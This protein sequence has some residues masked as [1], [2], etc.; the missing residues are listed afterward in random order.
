MLRNRTEAPYQSL[1]LFSIL[2]GLSN[3]A[4]IAVINSAAETVSDQSI[5]WRYTLLY[6]LVVGIF[7]YSKTLTLNW[8]SELVEK[9]IYQIRARLADKARRSE[10]NA[11]QNVGRPNIYARI[12]QDATMISNTSTT[13]INSA[14]S[15]VMIF[16]A[17]VYIAF[18]S[19]WSFALLAAGLAFGYLYFQLHTDKFQRLWKKVSEQ[20]TEFFSKLD[21]ILSG[22]KEIKINSL[23]NEK[24]FE[25]YLE[26]NAQLKHLR[27]KTSK[28]YNIA[29]IFDQMLFYFMLGVI[30]FVLPKFHTEHA[31]V[32]IKVVA[33]ILFIA[34]PLEGIIFSIPNFAN[35]NQSA[36]NILE[37]EAAL[38]ADL[39]EN[40][41]INEDHPLNS[42]LHTILPFESNIV[43]QNLTHQYDNKQEKGKSG[44]Q[45]GPIDMTLHKGEILFITGGNGSGKSTFVHL[46]TGLL[47]P[48]TGEILVDQSADSPGI[49]ITPQNISAYRNLFGAIFSNYHLFDKLYGI[50]TNKISIA[51]V[52]QALIEMGL[53]PEKVHYHGGQFS[54]LNLSSG[55]RKRIALATALL[56]DKDI[57]IFDEVA[58]DLDPVFRDYYYYQ[59][60]PALKKKG[61]TLLIISHDQQ[62]WKIADRILQF[63]DGKATEINDTSQLI[64]SE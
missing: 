31:E 32:M 48:D 44:F 19:F 46:L 58:A 1:L 41:Y 26:V 15:V 37:L 23:K 36:R 51:S 28:H 6:I 39:M 16:F 35:A 42:G 34:G 53:P 43:V 60:L 49:R 22:F 3:A 57:Y 59:F 45:S 9:V 5:N 13:M 64:D 50:P 24:V 25:S 21:H 14:Q 38:D 12:T 2:T 10:L 29:L 47:E 4:M 40:K 61:K 8:S 30:L 62:Y 11:L 55:Q 17:L 7:Y 27:I 63:K 54:G 18:V 33:S 56:E 20:Q 52:N